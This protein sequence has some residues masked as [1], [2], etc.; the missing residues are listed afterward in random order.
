[1]LGAQNASSV[2]SQAVRYVGQG[3]MLTV[4]NSSRSSARNIVVT[5]GGPSYPETSTRA[6]V[7]SMTTGWRAALR[8]DRALVGSL[9]LLASATG[10]GAVNRYPRVEPEDS[11]ATCSDGVDND[12]DGRPDCHD[13]GCAPFCGE[14]SADACAD[15]VDNDVDGQVDCDDGDCAAFCGEADALS[16]SDGVDND[17]DGATDCLDASCAAFCAESSASTCSD[18]RDN[19]FDGLSDCEDPSCDGFCPEDDLSTCSDGRDDDGDGFTDAQDPS[20]WPS[21]PPTVERCATVEGGRFFESFDLDQ[22]AWFEFGGQGA[23]GHESHNGALG[24]RRDPIASFSST[25]DGSPELSDNL[26]GFASNALFGGD[27][28]GVTLSFSAGVFNGAKLVVALTPAALAPVGDVPHHGAADALLSVTIDRG[29]QPMFAL[30]VE[31][32]QVSLP[33]PP[34]A[35]CGALFCNDGWTHVN[36][37]FDAGEIVATLD[38]LDEPLRSAA[39]ASRVVPP[40]RLVVWGGSSS[41]DVSARLD[42]LALEFADVRQCGINAPQI[43][44][45]GQACD[46]GAAKSAGM[47]VSLARNADGELCALLGASANPTAS[48]RPDRLSVWF[49]SDGGDT[50]KSRDPA[51]SQAALPLPAGATLVGGSVVWDP[52]A[53]R[54]RAAVSYEE[55]NGVRVAFSSSTDCSAWKK[56]GPGP[57]L[58]PDSE[59]PSY[60]LTDDRHELYFTRPATGDVRRTL[61]RA[62]GATQDAIVLEDTPLAELPAEAAADAPVS[63]QHVGPLDLVMTYRTVPFAGIT[64]LGVM[65]GDANGAIWRVLPSIPLWTATGTDFSFDADGVTAGALSWTGDGGVLLYG[66]I[67]RGVRAG[68]ARLKKAC[69]GEACAPAADDLAA[70]FCGD[71]I[72]QAWEDCERCAADCRCPGAELLEHPLADAKKWQGL[73][74]ADDA[75]AYLDESSEILHAGGVNQLGGTKWL[76]LPLELSVVGDFELSF[77]VPQGFLQGQ[78]HCPL[79]EVGLGTRSDPAASPAGAFAKLWG[80]GGPSTCIDLPPTALA[81]SGAEYES[82]RLESGCR[83]IAEVVSQAGGWARL[84]LRREKGVVSVARADGGQCLEPA[85]VTY[86]G[87]MPA[88]SSLFVGYAFPCDDFPSE[89]AI[90]HVELHL[91]EDPD[92]C[93]DDEIACKMS[94]AAATCVDVSTTPEHC[95]GCE[96]ACIPGAACHAGG[97]SCPEGTNEC[98]TACVDVLSSKDHCGACD[99]ACDYACADGECIVSDYSCSKP[100]FLPTDPGAVSFSFADSHTTRSVLCSAG[101]SNLRIF[102]WTPAIAGDFRVSVTAANPSEYV[103]VLVG[104]TSDR[105]CQSFDEC[106]N[107]AVGDVSFAVDINVTPGVTYNIAVGKY[108]PAQVEGQGTEAT[109]TV[110]PL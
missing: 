77:D 26:P 84:R 21:R 22:Q 98:P 100:Y 46:D 9:L 101:V 99:H 6:M 28:A 94:G 54:F 18:G 53:E 104:V 95:G 57:L 90:A 44:G 64:G 32:S 86:S 108:Y 80:M 10:C 42:D 87:A 68:T 11:L 35:V 92:A 45:P 20:C 67:R 102:S 71:G 63:L 107:G 103:D 69:A 43:P 109:L 14:S 75:T 31:G 29:S 59:P 88:L 48:E 78:R 39:P 8:L 12:L 41:E 1:V 96:H 55:T 82:E 50:W 110:S 106:G 34:L 4:V 17:G 51:A 47:T 93:A 30:T 65:V 66:G 2:E 7:E 83:S 19:D 25:V 79:L 3:L 72:C 23:F 15:L 85:S 89:S 52:A 62:T 49:S 58:P 97:C 38:G 37:R 13:A 33:L 16:C 81:I 5:R 61:W 27:L 56:L 76:E 24:E 70:A 74:G 40:S 105:A 36:V 91:L 73:G 60:V